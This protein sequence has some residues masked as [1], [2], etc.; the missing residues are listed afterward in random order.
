VERTN[1]GVARL[2]HWSGQSQALARH[3]GKVKPGMIPLILMPIVIEIVMAGRVGSI[4]VKMGMMMLH[5][6]PADGEMSVL[7]WMPA[8]ITIL[9]NLGIKLE[10]L[11]P[12]DREY[13]PRRHGNDMRNWFWRNIPT[14]WVRAKVALFMEAQPVSLA[15]GLQLEEQVKGK[16]ISYESYLPANERRSGRSSNRRLARSLR[17]VTLTCLAGTTID[18]M[19]VFD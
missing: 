10:L 14:S 11:P 17:L 4:V 16:E 9:C 19:M 13:I 18:C 2:M 5:G 6:T 1:E 7:A 3:N 8:I 12:E 15:V